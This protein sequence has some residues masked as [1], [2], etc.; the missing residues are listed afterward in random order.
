MERY[1]D[2]YLEMTDTALMSFTGVYFKHAKL[3]QGFNFLADKVQTSRF[4]MRTVSGV[5][6]EMAVI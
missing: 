3:Q 2:L 4:K 5:I 1:P 6:M